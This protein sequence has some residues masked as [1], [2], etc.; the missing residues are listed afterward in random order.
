MWLSFHWLKTNRLIQVPVL[1]MNIATIQMT[2][3]THWSWLSLQFPPFDHWRAA[4]ENETH[5]L[6]SF[7]RLARGGVCGNEGIVRCPQGNRRSKVS[8]TLRAPLSGTLLQRKDVVNQ[9]LESEFPIQS[10]ENEAPTAEN[11]MA[12]VVIGCKYITCTMYQSLAFRIC[13][14]QKKKKSMV[15]RHRGGHFCD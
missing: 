7:A 9:C 10:V 8:H 6:V 11:C 14:W 1:V 13:L 4:Q 3:D 2:G 12:F 5:W 15:E